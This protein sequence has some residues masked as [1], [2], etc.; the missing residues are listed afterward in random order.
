MQ[1]KSAGGVG[2]EYRK[3]GVLGAP[4]LLVA[5][6]WP[7]RARKVIRPESP[8]HPSDSREQR[9]AEKAILQELSRRL[10]YPMVGGRIDLKQGGHVALDG[11]SHE[12]R[13]ICEVFS[14]VG[15]LQ[16]G[17]RHKVAS[18]VL[19]LNLVAVELGGDWRK[20]LCFADEGAAQV[21]RGHSWLAA[22]AKRANIEVFVIPLEPTLH[23]QVVAAQGRQTMI[24]KMATDE[25]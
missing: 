16:P 10:G 1:I 7:C 6:S 25:D 15:T 23:D 12:H 4:S 8:L 13:V 18:D 5:L 14:R 21:L 24:N 9:G 3:C 11:V 22:A 19:K 2:K 17:Q 20:I